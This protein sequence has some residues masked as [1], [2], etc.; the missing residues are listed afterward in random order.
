MRQV[1]RV[2]RILGGVFACLATIFLLSGSPGTAGVAGAVVQIRASAVASLIHAAFAGTQIRLHNL[3]REH[4]EGTYLTWHEPNASLIRL[5]PLASGA[6]ARFTIPEH[7]V[8]A[9]PH[10]TLKYYVN[11]ITVRSM[12]AD[13]QDAG[14]RL[15]FR[16]ESA[17]AEL[18][19]YHTAFGKSLRDNGAPDL[20]LKRMRITAVLPPAERA[21]SIS[22]DPVRVDFNPEVVAA[23]TCQQRGVDLCTE[24]RRFR[25]R[26]KELV[27]RELTALLNREETRDR[28]AEAVQAHLPELMRV[29]RVRNF[30]AV[31][32]VTATGDSLTI[33]YVY[34]RSSA[35]VIARSTSW[36]FAPVR[37]VK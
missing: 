35:N 11:E 25:T 15:I 18:K 23:G 27:E 31:T 17:G 33:T 16:L 30:G 2:G 34:V 10:G 28:V 20:A 36:T 7:V 24:L 26:L 37:V 32:G 5:G 6:E 21:R 9:G 3:G 14:F 1:G 19:G 4:A 8:N 22:Y 12:G 29:A 13:W